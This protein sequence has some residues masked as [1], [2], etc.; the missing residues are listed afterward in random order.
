MRAVD[1]T[2]GT[3]SIQQWEAENCALAMGLEALP[4]RENVTE[5]RPVDIPDANDV[6]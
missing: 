2:D 6:R 5:C 4:V 3:V 1:T